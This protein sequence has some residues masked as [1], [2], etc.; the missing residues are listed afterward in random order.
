ME[1]LD[2]TLGHEGRLINTIDRRIE[3]GSDHQ[4]DRQRHSPGRLFVKTAGEAMGGQS[5]GPEAGRD[6][7]GRQR[8]EGTEGG[9]PETQE[10]LDEFVTA[11]DPNRQRCKK[12]R[13]ST[14]LE[15]GDATTATH[16]FGHL[17][18]S[19]L[20]DEPTIGDSHADGV[21]PAETIHDTT[22]RR[23]HL[24]GQRM[25]TTEVPR[26]ATGGERRDTRGGEFDARRDM[27]ERGPDGME[28]PGITISIGIVHDHCRTTTLRLATTLTD[29]DPLGPRHR[30]G[31]QHPTSAD[32]HCNIER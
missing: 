32:H 23:G 18:C 11:K 27:F 3:L 19:L 8:C 2:Q 9:D 16:L 14:G 1:L 13:R 25:I 24:G 7:G 22:H 5:L 29:L 31:R 28:E 10:H 15:Y 26:W 17:L 4:M 6:I 20:R 30:R 21:R 12:F